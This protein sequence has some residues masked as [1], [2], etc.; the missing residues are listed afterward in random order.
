MLFK[1][2]ENVGLAMYI[3]KD[4]LITTG[5]NNLERDDAMRLVLDELFSSGFSNL[6][7]IEIEA[8][9]NSGGWLILAHA[10][11][12]FTLEERFFSFRSCDDFIDA[13]RSYHL[14]GLEFRGWQTCGAYIA[15]IA[16][17]PK[18]V[19]LYSNFLLEYA[20]RIDNDE[21]LYMH[22][23]EHYA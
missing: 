9:E 1:Q 15:S 22:L 8:F 21:L 11:M 18:L 20:R 23:S 14:E 5:K 10:D 3:E 16:G 7:A 6:K 17:E 2:D 12:S 19:M 4:D 13:L